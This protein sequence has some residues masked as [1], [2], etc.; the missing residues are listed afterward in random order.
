MSPGKDMESAIYTVYGR[1][2]SENITKVTYSLSDIALRG[3]ICKPYFTK[4]NRS[5]QTLIVN[6]RYVIT[7]TYP[8]RYTIAIKTF[9]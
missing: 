4:H 6:G 3:Y 1:E 8:F 9:L 5:F 7:A 2:F